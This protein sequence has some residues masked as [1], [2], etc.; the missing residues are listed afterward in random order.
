[1]E[2]SEYPYAGSYLG[3]AYN[4]HWVPTCYFDG[5]DTVLV[6]GTSQSS[7]YTNRIVHAGARDVPDL[8]LDVSMTFIDSRHIEFTVSVTNNNFLN[9]APDAPPAPAGPEAAVTEDEYTYTATATDPDG[10]QIYYMWDWD[11]SLSEWSGPYDSGVPLDAAYTWST[12][13]PHDV[14]VKVKDQWDEE[15]P[16]SDPLT[17][18]VVE[19]GDANGDL[20]ISIG[21]AVALI[22]YIFKGGPPPEPL[23]AG[24]AN[25]DDSISIGDAVH[26]IEFI[27]KGGPPPGCP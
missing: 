14:R 17:I 12:T 19:R 21:D 8:D 20:D 16:W 22:S 27:F 9:F 15:S 7:P 10:D 24:D 4:Q 2:V 1:M 25:C 13:G 26:L 5:G 6:G 11:G 3:S 23:E 18:P